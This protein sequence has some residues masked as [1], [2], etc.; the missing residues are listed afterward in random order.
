MQR[1]YYIHSPKTRKVIID[2]HKIYFTASRQYI[3]MLLR[4]NEKGADDSLLLLLK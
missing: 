2:L 1:Q 4:E 3:E